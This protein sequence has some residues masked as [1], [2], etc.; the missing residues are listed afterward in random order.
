M[1]VKAIFSVTQLFD[2]TKTFFK[3]KMSLI[4]VEANIKN[5]K[6]IFYVLVTVD[7]KYFKKLL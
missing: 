5:R 7:E 3:V 6:K 2:K 4:W 1:R